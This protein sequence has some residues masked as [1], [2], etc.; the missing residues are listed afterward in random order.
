MI[1]RVKQL[2]PAI[3]VDSSHPDVL[4]LA[5]ATKG[6]DEIA[7]IRKSS[8]GA[9][10]AMNRVVEFLRSARPDG[11]HFRANGASPI[12]LGHVRTLIRETFLEHG[13]TETAPS[14]VSLGRD[15]GVPHNRGNDAD[16]VR[17]GMPLLVDIFPSEAGGG[18]HSDL[19]RTFCLGRAPAE[20]KQL[21]GQVR[22]AFDAAIGRL[23]LG[24]PC[25]SYQDT[26]CDIFE[27]HGH[28][29][30]RSRAGTEEGYVHGL[31]HGVGLSV[32]EEP[33]F[34][35]PPSNTAILEPGM[36]VTV[37]PGLYYPARGMG[38][39]IEDLVL[40]RPDGT[41]ENL[42]PVTYDLEIQPAG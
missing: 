4:T 17:A 36:V 25:R 31:G 21:Y 15:A 12:T 42:T 35:G 2:E 22:E 29:T 27:K 34:G 26:V 24:T 19:T 14:V 6:P 9:V 39:R 16:V 18:Y 28:A 3:E 23:E 10:A 8:N 40:A 37:E 11:D 13:L 7:A 38:V 32:H 5:R 30:P 1:E 20:L 33:R 41:F